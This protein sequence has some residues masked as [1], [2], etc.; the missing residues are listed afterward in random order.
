ML[1]TTIIWGAPLPS[2]SGLGEHSDVVAKNADRKRALLTF[3]QMNAAGARSRTL[4]A[5]LDTGVPSVS[6]AVTPKEDAIGLLMLAAEVEHS[7]MTS[8]LYTALSLRGTPANIVREVAAQEMGHLMTVQNLLLSLCGLSGEGIP[9]LIHLG[10]DGLRR[11][12]PR[13]PLPLQLMAASHEMMARFV[14]VERPALLLDP[15]LCARLDELERE[16]ET[17]GIS[18]NPLYALYAAI[19]WIFQ[20]DDAPDEVGL[21]PALG[22]KPGWHI[23]DGDFADAAMIAPFTAEVGEWGSVPELIV[24]PVLGRADALFAIDR[25]TAQGEGVP[26]A[27]NSHFSAFIGLLD[28]FDSGS[29]SVKPLPRSPTLIDPALHEDPQAISITNAYA[30]LWTSLFEHCYALLI[31]DIAWGY[32]QPKGIPRTRLVELCIDTM[33]HVIGDLS[34]HL[35]RLPLDVDATKKAGPS[36]RLED[37]TIPADVLGFKCRYAVLIGLQDMSLASIRQAPEFPSDAFGE[38]YLATIELLAQARKPYL[39]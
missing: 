34:V 39:P 32:A 15:Q 2:R 20:V 30:R 1:E 3:E 11:A 35:T 9:A 38:Q 33:R 17:D 4:E 29:V 10:R 14:V 8:Y 16:V 28:R 23:G 13:N 5:I 7:L 6:G 27:S 24:E 26:G 31:L 25:I 18:V 36:Y 21:S 37:E 19:R 22:L 12:S